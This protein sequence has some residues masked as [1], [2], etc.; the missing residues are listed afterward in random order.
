[1]FARTLGSL[2]RPRV[3]FSSAQRRPLASYSNRI[4]CG[5]VGVAMQTPF[6]RCMPEP[7]TSRT[8]HDE[9]A[10]NPLIV[11]SGP[12]GAQRSVRQPFKR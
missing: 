8:W 2:P 5:R 6:T 9:L 12:D 1:M 11:T 3:T 7:H 4:T 10:I